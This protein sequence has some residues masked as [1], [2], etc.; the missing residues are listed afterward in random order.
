MLSS[1]LTVALTRKR[2]GNGKSFAAGGS[3]QSSEKSR[4]INHL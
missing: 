2:S 3:Q 4:L 1:Y